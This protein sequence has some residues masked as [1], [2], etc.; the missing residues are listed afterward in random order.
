MSYLIC[1]VSLL[2]AGCTANTYRR[3]VQS[4]G[5]G[6]NFDRVAT[7]QDAGGSSVFTH[8][9]AVAIPNIPPPQMEPLDCVTNITEPNTQ[10]LCRAAN[11]L[12]TAANTE[13]YELVTMGRAHYTRSLEGIP[14]TSIEALNAVEGVHGRGR[15]KRSVDA[16]PDEELGIPD[17]FDVAEDYDDNEALPDWLK[18]N[19]ML[20][21]ED[22]LPTHTIGQL[23]AD[24]TDSP[25]PKTT[26]QLRD[27][28]V[29]VG[30]EIY[31]G[32]RE[33]IHFEHHLSAITT[34]LNNRVTALEHEGDILIAKLEQTNNNMQ[35][36]HQEFQDH[37][38][39]RIAVIEA[40][41]S[42]KTRVAAQLM[43]DIMYANSLARRIYTM[44]INWGDSI[45][46]N[47][48]AG[49]IPAAIVTREMIL[50]TVTMIEQR[51]LT[52]PAYSNL[53]LAQKNPEFYYNIRDIGYARLENRVAIT[54]D[55]PLIA[56]GGE[57]QAYRVST[58]PVP[59]LAGTEVSPNDPS[60]PGYT[61]MKFLPDY[62][63]ISNDLEKYYEMSRSEYEACT[64]GVSDMKICGH[65]LIA[66]KGKTVESMTCA[67]ALFVDDH[68]GVERHCETR[69]TNQVPIRSALQLAGDFSFLMHGGEDKRDWLMSCPYSTSGGTT[70]HIKVCDMCRLVVPCDCSVS[71]S[72]FFL[73]RRLSGCETTAPGV[74]PE[75]KILFHRNMATMTEIL[76]TEDLN[77]IRSTEFQIDKLYPPIDAPVI[78]FTAPDDIPEF[79]AKSDQEEVDFRK[80]MKN[81]KAERAIYKDRFDEAWNK[82]VDFTGDSFGREG[83]ILGAAE[84]FFKGILG[85]NLWAFISGL[86]FG[87]IFAFIALLFACCTGT[88][89]VIRNRDDPDDEQVELLQ[90]LVDMESGEYQD[91][92]ETES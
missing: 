1:I 36:H 81:A 33:L 91:E 34:G 39:D 50:E 30:N 40:L 58:N 31:D 13:M 55:M 88:R 12:I 67:Y 92:L 78:E 71:A 14:M 65:G 18:E 83:D 60:D 77:K 27:H 85:S 8:T 24:V 74:A 75:S 72:H 3:S 41:D 76:D 10:I 37:W 51:V 32:E 47:L 54:V 46:R 70:Q 29:S 61:I 23:W 19:P 90:T 53:Q 84:E 68:Q 45:N 20:R 79:V 4:P 5:Y 21:I 38:A 73:P 7:I 62:F 89:Y 22:N 42:F 6:V 82:T 57:L 49:Y 63:L 17:D 35:L 9:W 11:E 87:L 52:Q 25:G 69:Q 86:G 64:G 2:I 28:L 43:P 80:L 26:K 16:S 15:K 59:V 56:T 44:Y 66:S 48:Q